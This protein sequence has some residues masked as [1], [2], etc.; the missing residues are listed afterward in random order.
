VYRKAGKYHVKILVTQTPV[1]K[2][3]G[4]KIPLVLAAITTS[5]VAS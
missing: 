3:A 1:Q 5:A 4:A 2:P